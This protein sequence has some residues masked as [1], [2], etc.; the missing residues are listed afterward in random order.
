LPDS[1]GILIITF[2]AMGLT[3]FGVRAIQQYARQAPQSKSATFANSRSNAVPRGGGLAIVAVVLMLLLPIGL[4]ISDPTPI[5]RIALAGVMIAMIGF[6]DD[7]QTLSRPYRLAAQV[8]AVLIFTPLTPVQVLVLPNWTIIVPPWLGILISTAWTVG[9]LNVFSYMDNADGLS[10]THAMLIA[11]LWGGLAVMLGNRVAVLLA[12][13]LFGSSFGFLFFNVPPARIFMGEVGSTF[14]GF[15][16][17]TLSLLVQNQVPQLF[18][19]GILFA[20][21]LVFDAI[22]TFIRYVIRGQ[23]G[24]HPERSHLYQRLLQLGDPPGRVTLIYL[25]ITVLFCVA[26]IAYFVVP[27]WNAIV[28]VAVSCL[29]LFTWVKRRERISTD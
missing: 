16:L 4:W 8:L 3:W 22:F 29:I 17:A 14:V 10:N 23:F 21:L 11:L 13:L 1:L 19:A 24:E 5:V 12:A 6:M 27:A 18:V 20:G 28:V 15:S 7:R 2:S 9:L 25:L 26:G